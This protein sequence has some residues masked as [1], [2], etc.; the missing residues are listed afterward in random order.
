MIK[1]DV[2]MHTSF[3]HDSKAEPEEMIK[4]AVKKGMESICFTDHYDKDDLEWGEESIFDPEA[5]FQKLL[6]LKEKYEGQI[7][8]RIGVETGLQPHLGSYYKTFVK[9]YPFDFVIGSVHAVDFMDPALGKLFIHKTDREAYLVAFTEMLKNVQSCKDFDVL[10][11][12]DYVVRYGAG[13]EKE[14]SYTVFSDIFDAILKELIAQGKGLELNTSGLKYGLPFAHPH[15]DILNRY[16]E[17]GG[18]IVTVGADG[19]CPEH[20]AYDFHV[21]EQMLKTC[22]FKYYTEF[23]D[24][25]PV[26]KQLP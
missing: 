2:H 19:H 22:G 13:R 17:L 20:I 15:P 24:R 6:P 18:E 9:R 4:C 11:H 21:A 12:V 23:V 10:G 8:V 16:R 5:Y 14:Y 26:F 25:A 7:A 1:S 3:S